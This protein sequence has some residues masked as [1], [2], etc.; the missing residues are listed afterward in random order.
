MDFN[1]YWQENKRFVMTVVGGLIVFLIS[2]S[3]INSTIGGE[4]KDKR[5]ELTKLRSDLG[6]SRYQGSDLATARSEN[7]ALEGVVETLAAAVAFDTRPEFQLDASSGTSGNQY[8]NRVTA[9]REDLLRRAN[10]SNVRV[11][12]DLGLPALAP[13]RDEDIARHLDALDVIERVLEVAIAE[14][15]ARIEK[16]DI[17][18][19]PGLHGRK[20]VGRVEKTRITMKMSGPSA[21]ILR[22]LAATQTPAGGKSLIV[23]GVT[24]VPERLKQDEAKLEVTFLAPRLYLTDPEEVE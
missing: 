1:D 11:V 7:E 13:T 2:L 9:V 14:G 4:L 23:E 24:M 12:P 15:V 6:K 3:V 10:R 19:D 18:L 20:G 22:L 5:R 17:R 16:I 21:P 8:F